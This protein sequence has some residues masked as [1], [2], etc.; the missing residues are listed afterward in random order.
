MIQLNPEINSLISCILNGDEDAFAQLCS[1][2]DPLIRSMAKKYTHMSGV[3]DEKQIFE[4]FVQEATFALYR[5][6]RTYESKDGQ[7]SFGLYSKICIRNALVSELRRMGRKKKSDK[8]HREDVRRRTG[9]R[10]V[11]FGESDV[12]EFVG[13]DLLSD[14]E[15]KVFDM[16]VSGVKVRDM[17]K[18]LNCSAK[19][20]SNAVYRMKTKVKLSISEDS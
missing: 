10:D 18:I 20:V 19:S 3:S 6:A 2:Y 12:N 14:F 17:A 15:K 13:R 16:Y 1:L 5:A 11:F 9:K 8:E 4:D 7:V